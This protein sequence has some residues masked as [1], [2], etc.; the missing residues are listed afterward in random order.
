M[1][2][3]LI[4]PFII[5]RVNTIYRNLSWLGCY[6]RH[7]WLYT[8]KRGDFSGYLLLLT[9]ARNCI[10]V[11]FDVLMLW[12]MDFGQRSGSDGAVQARPSA[13]GRGLSPASIRLHSVN[14][15]HNSSLYALLV[16][17]VHFPVQPQLQPYIMLLGCTA[18]IACMWSDIL[19][20]VQRCMWGPV[21][22]VR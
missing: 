15:G 16:S 19:R 6:I 8:A 13:R 1:S 22:L 10:R 14:P 11:P 4:N 9:T 20:H 5:Y 2:M 12:Q 3:E 18:A 17:A 7:Y 21:V